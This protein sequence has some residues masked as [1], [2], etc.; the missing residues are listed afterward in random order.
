VVSH[1]LCHGLPVLTALV[2][3]GARAHFMPEPMVSLSYPPASQ[4]SLK[5]LRDDDVCSLILTQST[6]ILRDVC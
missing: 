5:L 6:Y 3:M 2:L 1:A 4:I